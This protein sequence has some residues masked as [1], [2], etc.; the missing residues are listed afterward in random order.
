MPIPFPARLT[1]MAFLTAAT[2][3]L[4]HGDTEIHYAGI[5]AGAYAV[6]AE[7]RAKPGMENALREA[8][9]PLVAQVRAEPNNLVYFLHEDRAA[10]GHFVFY[11]IFVSQA[12]FEAHN[13]TP[14]VQAWFARLPELADGGVQ[15]VKMEILG[16]PPAAED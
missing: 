5:P 6:V 1:L 8:T 14:H 13:A 4:A 9:L 16:N 10:P 15:V 2:P 12:D 11:E 3:A 7:V